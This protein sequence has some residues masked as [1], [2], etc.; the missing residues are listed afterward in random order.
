MSHRLLRERIF[1]LKAQTVDILKT[2][3]FGNTAMIEKLVQS[4]LHAT[5]GM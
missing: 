2:K 5:W 4:P 1:K 3:E